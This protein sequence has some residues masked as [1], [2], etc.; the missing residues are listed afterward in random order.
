MKILDP[1]TRL[2][3]DGKFDD[4]KYASFY[5]LMRLP[6]DEITSVEYALKAAGLTYFIAALTDIFGRKINNYTDLFKNEDALFIAQLIYH[7]QVLGRTNT[8]QVSFI[9]T[10]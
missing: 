2:F 4:T 1:L 10:Y 3:T 6:I 8:A 5:S 7:H 9:Y